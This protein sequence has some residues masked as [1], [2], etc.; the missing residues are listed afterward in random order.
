[1]YGPFLNMPH[2]KRRRCN[3]VEDVARGSQTNWK[4]A[5]TLSQQLPIEEEACVC[6]HVCV[7]MCVCMCVCVCA[8]V[9]VCVCRHVHKGCAHESIHMHK[10]L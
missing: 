2:R 10:G 9:C 8:C 5:R 4:V 3:I 7:W 6:V 1:M